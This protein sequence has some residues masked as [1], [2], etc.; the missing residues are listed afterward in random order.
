MTIDSIAEYDPELIILDGLD[1]AIIGIVE[2][3]DFCA[4]VYDTEKIIT[5][6]IQRD[7]MDRSD[8]MDFFYYNIHCLYAGEKTPVFLFKQ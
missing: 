5:I 3:S 1:D 4:I 6:L 8:A 2:R 7:K